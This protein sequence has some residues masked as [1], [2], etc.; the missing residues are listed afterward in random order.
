MTRFWPKPH[1]TRIK[2]PPI[3]EQGKD[4]NV[5]CFRS[6]RMSTGTGA[7]GGGGRGMSKPSI[8]LV[9]NPPTEEDDGGEGQ[10]RSSTIRSMPK[11][12][13]PL[14]LKLCLCLRLKVLGREK[15]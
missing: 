7:G 13:L 2:R 15:W 8:R 3:K 9:V 6:G 11:P 10:W 4:L 12:L 5:A 14:S 1:R